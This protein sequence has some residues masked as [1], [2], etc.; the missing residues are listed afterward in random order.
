MMTAGDELALRLERDLP[1]PRSLVFRMHADS[2]RWRRW[3]GPDGFSVPSIE[4]DLR[5]G[6]G[7]RIEMQPPDGDPFFLTGEFRE[8][9]PPARLAYAFAWEDPDPD[10]QETVVT[11]SLEDL[12][13]ERTRLVVA[14]GAIR[15]RGAPSAAHARLDRDAR[16][17]A[18]VDH[19]G[20]RDPV[21][22]AKESVGGAAPRSSGPTF[23]GGWQRSCASLAHHGRRTG[24]PPD[25]EGDRP[26]HRAV[27]RDDRRSQPPA[28]RRTTRGGEP[29]RRDHRAGRRDVRAPQRPCGRGP[30]PARPPID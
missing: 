12:G 2:D 9:E 3:W 26:R 10:D 27:H 5:V 4:V 8:V 16:S 6:G 25:T 28:L 22:G 15:H 30:P 23:V 17:S 29:I 1:A 11:F 24:C 18:A 19:R 14:R 7:F 21:I 13:E 20:D